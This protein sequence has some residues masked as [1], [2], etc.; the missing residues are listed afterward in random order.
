MEVDKTGPADTGKAEFFNSRPLVEVNQLHCEHYTDGIFS[1]H[2]LSWRSTRI[3]Q[4]HFISGDF[5]THDLS[6]RSTGCPCGNTC[7]RSFSTHDLSWRSTTVL[8]H[9]RKQKFFQL[10]TSRGDRQNSKTRA[11]GRCLFNSR[12]L[13]EIDDNA[14]AENVQQIFSTHDLSWRSTGAVS[15]KEFDEFF[16]LT[17]SRGDRLLL[18]LHKMPT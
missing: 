14:S 16:Q 15:Q 4:Y 1:T 2:D 6:W 10:T 5:S 3:Y 7:N 8:F 18:T 13:V 9:W 11:L 17:T 12:P